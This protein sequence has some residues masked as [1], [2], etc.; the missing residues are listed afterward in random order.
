M[1]TAGALPV[2]DTTPT[3][4]IPCSVTSR[5]R[6]GL[7]D[8]VLDSALDH[9]H[10]MLL[11]AISVSPPDSPTGSEHFIR[12]RHRLELF[13]RGYF[14]L[15]HVRNCLSA[16]PMRACRRI[17]RR[18]RCKGILGAAVEYSLTN[19]PVTSFVDTFMR[20]HGRHFGQT[21]LY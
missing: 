4:S 10:R 18:Q 6:P 12:F 14:I 1:L 2:L 21:V 17:I 7:R 13:S 8:K 15:S 3:L 20:H 9:I 5:V 19:A 16:Q 11:T